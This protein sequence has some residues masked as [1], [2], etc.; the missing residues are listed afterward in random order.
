MRMLLVGGG[1]AAL[2]L[3]GLGKA[4]KDR[5]ACRRCALGF[6]LVWSLFAALHAWLPLREVLAGF[7]PAISPRWV[8]AIALLLAYAIAVLAGFVL[9]RMLLSRTEIHLPYAVEI[10]L[11][12]FAYLGLV[13]LPLLAALAI[14]TSPLRYAFSEENPDQS[15]SGIV[16]RK[17]LGFYCRSGAAVSGGNQAPFVRHLPREVTPGRTR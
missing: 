16:A 7:L 10:S 15:A 8:A 9:E 4:L 17:L 14:H 5:S 1:V 6:T 13:A 12:M 3:V 2:A 11:G